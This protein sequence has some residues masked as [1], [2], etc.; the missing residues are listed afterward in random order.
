MSDYLSQGDQDAALAAEIQQDQ[1]ALDVL[2]ATT[3]AARFQTDQVRAQVAQQA[4]QMQAQEAALVVAR[5]QL[6]ILEAQT[7]RLQAQQLAAFRKAQLNHAQATALLAQEQRSE[8]EPAAPDRRA[9][10]RA[11]RRAA[12][13]RR[14]TAARSPGRWSAAITPGVRVH[15]LPGRAAA[16]QLRP[17]PPRHRHRRV[18]TG[19]RS[20]RPATASSSSWATTRTIRRATGPGS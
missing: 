2:Q 19:R 12:A 3:Q 4:V 13:S 11:R 1:Q 15:R 5:H 6:D 20:A 10:R 14:S 16:R 8:A 9:D 18:P 17:L 7:K